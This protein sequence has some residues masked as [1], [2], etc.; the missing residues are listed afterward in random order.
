VCSSDLISNTA[1]YELEVVHNLA[2]GFSPQS[3]RA[4]ANRRQIWVY[5]EGGRV[6][7]TIA[8]E[9]DTISGFFVAP[10]R[11]G[12][13]IGRKLLQFM[14]SRGRLKG[15]KTLRLSASL[16]AVGFYEKFG[17]KPF[18]EEGGDDVYGRVVPMRKP[19]QP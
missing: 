11:Q 13:G 1:D 16:T 19:L 7:A 6:T 17:Y 15:L 14:E 2:R 12:R 10:D 9:D 3:L 8:L 4:M 18:G 5:D